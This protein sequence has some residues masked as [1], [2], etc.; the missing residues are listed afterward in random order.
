MTGAR[1]ALSRRLRHLAAAMTIG[2]AGVMASAPALARGPD[3]IADIA[4][5]VID[6][7]VNI[8]TSQTVEAKGGGGGGGGA[9]PQLPPGSPFE[10]FFDDFFKNRRGGP[11]QGGKESNREFQPRKTNSLG[12]GFIIDTAGIVVTNNH[13]IADADEINVILNDGTKIKA[14]LV[15]VDKKTDLAVLKFKPTKPLIA[16]KFGDSDKLRLGEWVIAIGNPFS[17]GGSVTAGIVSARNRDISQG[18]YDNYIQTDASINRGNSG[19]PL[20]NLEGEVVGVNTLIISPTGG[21]IG[22]GFAVPSK[23]VAA[24][25]DQLQKFG[26]LRRGWLGVRIQPVTE[27]IA[28]SLSIKP[29]RGALVAGVDDKG[30]AKPAGI[31]PGDVV[32]RFDGKDVKDP[33]DL[34]RVVADTAVGKDVDVVVIRKG[35]EESRKVTLGRLEDTDKA[36][37]AAAKTKE[38]PA[39]KPV[40]QKALGLDLATLSKDLRTKYKIKDSVKG[41]IVTGVDNNS[42]AAEKR[43]SAGDVIVEVAQEAVSNAGDVKKRVDQVKKDGKK[44]V[45]LLVANGEGELRFVALSVQ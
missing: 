4:E 16:V 20:F 45:L 40:T 21:S 18:P 8:S 44:S 5:K 17:L 11:G 38:E 26:E 9:S 27:E 25:V 12:S 10:E 34:S 29:A 32:I 36:K 33:K 6:A 37:E 42:D 14:E 24:V 35:K 23:T 31:E 2:V 28:E 30:P 15:G 43:L 19:G 3:G 13:V 41:V 7:V 39:E 22:L 1:P